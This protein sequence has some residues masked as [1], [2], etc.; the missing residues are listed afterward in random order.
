M[1]LNNPATV[2]WGL[3]PDRDKQL[4]TFVTTLHAINYVM[5]ELPGNARDS[6][7]ILGAGGIETL[8]IDEIRA[9]YS[10]FTSKPQ[11]SLV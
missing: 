6:A 11:Q 5:S 1:N 4:Q 9:I 3:G 7:V 10:T 8:R 2:M